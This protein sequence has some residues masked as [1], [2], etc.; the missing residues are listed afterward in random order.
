MLIIDE[1]AFTREDIVKMSKGKTSELEETLTWIRSN[2]SLSIVALSS[3]SLLD[4]KYYDHPLSKFDLSNKAEKWGYHCLTLSNVMRSS[5]NIA[6]ATNIEAV[7]S[8]S[9]TGGKIEELVTSGSSSTVPGTRPK[10][11][12]YKYTSGSV[13]Y[14]KLLQYTYTEARNDSIF[15]VFCIIIIKI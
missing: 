1:L 2:T 12:I 9:M 5:Q 4:G 3:S 15:V 7:M 14:R 13:D 6:R 11:M 10:A 8:L